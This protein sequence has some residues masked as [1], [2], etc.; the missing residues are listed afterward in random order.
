MPATGYDGPVQDLR[1]TRSSAVDQVAEAVREM[2]LRG[3]L[4]PGTRLRE[5]HRSAVMRARAKHAD[6]PWASPG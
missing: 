4:A 2:I 5:V 1:S 3:E 6:R